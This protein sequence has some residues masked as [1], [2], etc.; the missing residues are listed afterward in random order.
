MP[1][2]KKKAGREVETAGMMRWLL[3]YADMI[4]LLLAMFIL[5]Y[6]VSKINL[7]K[8]KK[9][10]DKEIKISVDQSRLRPV[11]I[12]ILIGSNDKIKSDT[13]WQPKIAIEDTLHDSFTSWREKLLEEVK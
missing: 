9:F 10:T 11:D 6:A 4:T 7:E 8:Y 12:P 3:T 5:L 1:I 13:G 2:R